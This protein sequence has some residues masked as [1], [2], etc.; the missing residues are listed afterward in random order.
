MYTAAREAFLR[1]NPGIDPAILAVAIGR[2]ERFVRQYQR[3]L[4][5]RPL[6]GNWTKR[7]PLR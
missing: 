1:A 5:I 4:G 6:T 7:T 2:T 3:R